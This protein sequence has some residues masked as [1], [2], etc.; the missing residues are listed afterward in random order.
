LGRI[1]RSM[2]R[3][4][5]VDHQCG[6]AEDLAEPAL[7]L[8]HVEA[9]APD[10]ETARRHRP[11]LEGGDLRMR[12]SVCR[13]VRCLVG[14]VTRLRRDQA[15]HPS[16]PRYHDPAVAG[17]D[18][19][20]AE[21]LHPRCF[22]VGSD[23][24]AG[25]LVRQEQDVFVDL[26]LALENRAFLCLG[27]ADYEVLPARVPGPVARTGFLGLAFVE[28]RVSRVA[29]GGGRSGAAIRRSQARPG[30]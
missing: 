3:R 26:A 22:T 14:Q 10:S 6:A 29:E 13:G 2:L 17:W 28:P 19:G 16:G 21:A 25:L 24:G 18:H 4:E 1:A 12:A 27:I 9:V 15:D 20:D 30:I 7:L 11:W 5:H 23:L 8:G